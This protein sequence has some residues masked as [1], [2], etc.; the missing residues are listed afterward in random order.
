MR[1]EFLSLAHMTI[2]THT[3][4]VDGGH[5]DIRTW[6]IRGPGTH[7]LTPWH[8]WTCGH[9]GVMRGPG[10]TRRDKGGT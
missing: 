4:R 2:W 6:G 7:G 9:G 1:N 3:F 8:T 10:G 5:G